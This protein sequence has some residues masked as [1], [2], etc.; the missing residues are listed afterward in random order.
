MN[1]NTYIEPVELSKI[2][3]VE[4][5]TITVEGCVTIDWVG[6]DF[7]VTWCRA[8]PRKDYPEC[9]SEWDVPE[10]KFAAL[11][12]PSGSIPLNDRALAF[13]TAL[14]LVDGVERTFRL[15]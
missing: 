15:L 5:E 2:T 1:I 9:E 7:L 13:T 4:G 10:I 8:Y 6:F 11:D 14:Y 3:G 12:H